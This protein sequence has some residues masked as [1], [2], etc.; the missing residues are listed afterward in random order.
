MKN[1][2]I[3]FHHIA[4]YKSVIRGWNIG[5]ILKKLFSLFI[6]ITIHVAYISFN[7]LKKIALDEIIN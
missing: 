7:H 2:L 5:Q 3:S 1:R 4:P 6:F